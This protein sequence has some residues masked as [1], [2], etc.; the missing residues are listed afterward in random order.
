MIYSANYKGYLVCPD[1]SGMACQGG[2]NE[3]GVQWFNGSSAHEVRGK[4]DEA[5]EEEARIS[6]AS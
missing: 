2:Y 4:I 6:R 1:I 3:S 5:I